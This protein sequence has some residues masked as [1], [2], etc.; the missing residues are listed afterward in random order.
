MP[1]RMASVGSAA[2]ITVLLVY[3]AAAGLALATPASP[4]PSGVVVYIVE[5]PFA[6]GYTPKEITVVVG[7]NN[8]VTWISR[9]TSYDTVTSESGLFSSGSIQ[10]GG[11]F[12]Y[13]FAN[14]G[15]YAYHCVFHPWMSGRV[16]VVSK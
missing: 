8:T 10:P 11:S 7:V 14:P 5:T 15:V 2:L 3:F 4:P 9:S 1:A 6:W 16:T 12:S 13:A